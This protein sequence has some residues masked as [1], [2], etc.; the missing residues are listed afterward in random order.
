[1]KV[2]I[3]ELKYNGELP[4][5]NCGGTLV[6]FTYNERNKVQCK[7]EYY[8]GE[9]KYENIRL[10]SWRCI[11]CEKMFGKDIID[12]LENNKI[13]IGK[14]IGLNVVYKDYNFLFNKISHYIVTLK[15]N[16]RM[17]VGISYIKKLSEGDS[18]SFKI[19]RNDIEIFNLV[20]DK[21]YGE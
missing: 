10:L 2:E 1:M 6:P 8:G 18:V 15:A 19:K 9:D 4:L 13:Y 3:D 12:N 11:K 5:C 16:D 20:K 17:Y 21:I 7:I 14:I